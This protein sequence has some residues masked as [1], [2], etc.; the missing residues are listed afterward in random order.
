MSLYK[1]ARRFLSNEYSYISH[2]NDPGSIG[3]DFVV[4]SELDSLA[5]TGAAILRKLQ[6][7]SEIRETP[8]LKHVFTLERSFL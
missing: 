3:L 8:F 1:Y 5:D 4:L 7:S 2:S 6:V